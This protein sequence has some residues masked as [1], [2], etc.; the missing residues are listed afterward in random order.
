M[1]RCPTCQSIYT[2]DSLSYC[3]QDGTKLVTVSDSS[4]EA[5]WHISGSGAGRQ[6]G[7]EPPP[8]EIL[9]P[10]DMPTARIEATPPTR[11]QQRARPTALDEDEQ[12]AIRTAP[13]PRRSNATV[14]ALSALVALLLVALGGLIAWIMLRDKPQPEARVAPANSNQAEVRPANTNTA[15]ANANNPPSA[16]TTPQPSPVDVSAVRTEV[17]AALNG[18]AG[19][20]R[21]R[22]LEEHMK[23][24]ADVLDVYYNATN[25]SRDRVRADR[26]AA[27]DK[28][29]SLEMQVSNLNIDVDPSGTRA[30]ATFDKSFEF[31]NDEKTYSGSGLN[32]FWFVKTGGRWRITGEKEL[33]SYYINK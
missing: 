8:T 21:Q 26:S 31:S 9:R 12:T 14:I 13:A 3:L 22:N 16:N 10:E 18:W 6:T 28:Y 29:S 20:V 27:F 33:K 32:R 23:Y 1:K 11:E 15:R 5:T 19:T 17:Q 7:N 25:V 24:Y 30:T 2:D 4:A